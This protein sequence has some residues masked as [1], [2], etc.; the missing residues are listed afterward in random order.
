MKEKIKNPKSSNKNE[1]ADKKGVLKIDDIVGSIPLYCDKCGSLH[2]KD[3]IEIIDKNENLTIIY[4]M[5][6][7]CLSKNIMYVIKPL[8][9]INKTVINVDL[10][11]SEIKKFA[12][13]KS[14]N[15]DDILNIYSTIKSKKISKAKDFI[16]ELLNRD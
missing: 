16:D 11:S 8:N 12:G 13:S 2:D 9:V 3:S 4:M 1:S 15:T 10:E 5:C 14:I 7:N 6:E